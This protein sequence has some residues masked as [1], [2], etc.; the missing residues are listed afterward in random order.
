[1]KRWLCI[2]LFVSIIG[3]C[4]VLGSNGVPDDDPYDWHQTA[5]NLYENMGYNV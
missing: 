2:L 5:E 4:G 1:M 3:G